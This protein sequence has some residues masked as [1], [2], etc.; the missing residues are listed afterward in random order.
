MKPTY[1]ATKED[2]AIIRTMIDNEN[3]IINDRITWLTTIQGF[4]FAALGFA[5]D[6][7]DARA[8]I[9]IASFLGIGVALASWTSFTISNKARKDLDGWWETH[10]PEDY[11]GPPVIGI[12]SFDQKTPLKFLIRSLRPWRSLPPFFILGWLFVLVAHL[13]RL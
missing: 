2:A 4:L 11:G 9:V 8:V 10:K 6:K 13:V 1:I 7:N 12:R 5:W 3:R